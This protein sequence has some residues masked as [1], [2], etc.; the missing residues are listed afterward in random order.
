MASDAELINDAA[1][2]YLAE[3]QRRREDHKVLCRCQACCSSDVPVWERTNFVAR[4]TAARHCKEE[5]RNN[6]L[7]P[8]RLG[9]NADQSFWKP[10]DV[11]TVFT[12]EAHQALREEAAAGQTHTFT[13]RH[14]ALSFSAWHC[15]LVSS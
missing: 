14:T 9:S 13:R 10:E 2:Q 4:G 11:V 1:I 7:P 5:R 6:N 15:C 8:L 12:Q 3:L